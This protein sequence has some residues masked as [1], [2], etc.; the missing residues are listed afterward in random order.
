VGY[1]CGCG[2]YGINFKVSF[3]SGIKDISEVLTKFTDG[4]GNGVTM[5]YLPG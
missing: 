3:Y 5:E 4:N 1:I 2:E